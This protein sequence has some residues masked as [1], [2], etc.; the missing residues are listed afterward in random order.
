MEM[1]IICHFPP[2]KTSDHSLSLYLL[3]INELTLM[4]GYVM[5]GNRIIVPPKLSQQV[6]EELHTTHLGAVK[7]KAMT[8]SY[9]WWPGL[10]AQI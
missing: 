1:D 8:C 9:V 6:L 2:S 10:D 3:Q 5:Q 7:M 4:Q